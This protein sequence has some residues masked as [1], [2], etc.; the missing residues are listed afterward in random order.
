LIKSGELW[1]SH[2]GRRVVIK[3]AEIDRFLADNEVA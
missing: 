1:A 2:V 3:V